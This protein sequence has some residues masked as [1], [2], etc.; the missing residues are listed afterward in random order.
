M[1][2]TETK[3]LGRPP[4]YERALLK[5]VTIRL[6]DSMNEQIEAIAE[7]RADAPDKAQIIRELLAIGLANVEE[8]A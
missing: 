4:V 1:K 5:P 6:P 3:R 7:A 8:P 2:K